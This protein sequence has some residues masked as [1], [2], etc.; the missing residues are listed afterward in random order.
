MERTV[1]LA[2]EALPERLAATLALPA[3][4]MRWMPNGC[5]RWAARNGC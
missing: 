1:E 2:V 3:G 5:W 4:A